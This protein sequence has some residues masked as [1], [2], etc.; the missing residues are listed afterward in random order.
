MHTHPADHRAYIEA[1]HI[2]RWNIEHCNSE[3]VADVYLSTGETVLRVH[4]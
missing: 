4:K 2:L 3:N 1:A